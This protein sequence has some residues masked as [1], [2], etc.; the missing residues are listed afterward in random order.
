MNAS[1]LEPIRSYSPS[2]GWSSIK[3]ARSLVSKRLIKWVGTCSSISAWNDS[4]I[5][6]TR[7]R[8]ANKNL[9][10]IYPDTIVDSLLNSESRIWNFQAIQVLV[11]PQDVKII[12]SI[13][14]SRNQ[15]EDRDGWHFTNNE[16]YTVKSRYQVERIYPDKEK[17]PEFYGPIVDIL[18]AFCWKVRC[19][20]KIKHFLWQLLLRCIDV[21]KNLKARGIQGD[22]CCARC[23]APEESIIM[24]SLNVLQHVKCG[25]FQRYHR[26]LIFSL[27]VLFSQIWTIFFGELAQKWMVTNLHGC[28]G[29]FGKVGTTKF[30][31]IWILT[32]EKHLN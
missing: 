12:E 3:S 29:I 11:D 30:L 14:L 16:K 24:C 9:H 1:S 18:K 13:P 26:I 19:P 25:H 22:I 27:S 21:M 28:Y 10:N 8:P 17:S 7:L 31:V 2:Y 32:Q 4:W 23:G 5:S 15:L 6:T 20:P